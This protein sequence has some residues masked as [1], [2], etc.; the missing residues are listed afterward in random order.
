MLLLKIYHLSESLSVSIEN[1][2]CFGTDLYSTGTPYRNLLE[3]LVTMT[4]MSGSTQEI[5]LAKTNTV[6]K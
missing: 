4:G 5:A 6:K 3:S 1:N 2:K